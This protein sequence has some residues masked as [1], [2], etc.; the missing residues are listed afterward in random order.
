MRGEKESL[1]G[2]TIAVDGVSDF[3]TIRQPNQYIIPGGAPN[4][5]EQL[6]ICAC[7]SL[8]EYV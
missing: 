2:N 8:R 3:G 7:R 1:V 4:L 5:L 6:T